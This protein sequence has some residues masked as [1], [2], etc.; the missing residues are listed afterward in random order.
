MNFWLYGYA[1]SAIPVYNEQTDVNCAALL[2][3]D[4]STQ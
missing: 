2:E 3:N 4:P 1:E